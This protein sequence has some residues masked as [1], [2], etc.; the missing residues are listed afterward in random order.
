[1]M[2]F[3][4]FIWW[5]IKIWTIFGKIINWKINYLKNYLIFHDWKI[6]EIT[7]KR[8]RYIRYNIINIIIFEYCYNNNKK[9]YVSYILKNGYF[10]QIN[11]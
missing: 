5:L 8:S 9:Q 11:F 4:H 3:C 2:L 1:M 6:P 7:F 10:Y